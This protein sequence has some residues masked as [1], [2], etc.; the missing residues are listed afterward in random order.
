MRMSKIPAPCPQNLYPNC[1]I[2]VWSSY[3]AGAIVA[4]QSAGFS[5]TE[6][7]LTPDDY[8]HLIGGIALDL[9]RN[10]VAV[11]DGV[12]C[13]KKCPIAEEIQKLSN[14]LGEPR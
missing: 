2:G 6:H 7:S 1:V 4:G 12:P 11:V 9:L 3:E 14:D 13:T 10:A 8:E 5:E